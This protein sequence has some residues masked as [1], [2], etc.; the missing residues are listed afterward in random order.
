MSTRILVNNAV[1]SLVS[2]LF[3]RGSLMLATI[4]LARNLDTTRFAIYSYFALT[5]AMLATYASMGLGVTASRFF[6]EV[7]HEREDRERPPL[8]ALWCLSL[9]VSATFAGFVLS[10]PESWLSA[11]L[12]IPRWLL[13]LGTLVMALGVVPGG[14]II[15]LEMYRQAAYVSFLAGLA[16]LV[17]TSLAAMLG[18]EAIAMGTFVIA[19]AINSTGA[20]MLVLRRVGR[21]RLF[22]R[23]CLHRKDIAKVVSFAAPMLAVSFVSGSGAWLLGRM[24]LRGPDGE[25]AFALYSIG[26]QWFAL[27]LLIPGML[28]RVVL[29]RLVRTDMSSEQGVG[30]SRE[31]VR[32]GASLALVSAAC[33]AILGV[34]L[35]PW[36]VDIY[37]AKYD[38]GRW[39]IAAF[40]A[41]AILS[42]PANLVGNAIVA[43]DGQATW[44]LLTLAWL[45]T[46]LAVG[47]FS[48]PMGAWAGAVSQGVAA[49]VLSAL[50]VITARGSRF[51]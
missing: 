3:F 4:V 23:G 28:S 8:G 10:I 26:L 16:L 5:L 40:M 44:L 43:R 20:A 14:A 29:P 17:G 24:I 38:A 13:A 33:V 18:S 22:S 37:G 45:A 48:L 51:I 19:F 27:A 46:L 6:A 15:G 34:A 35:G 32:R 2:H 7:G 30:A 9:L 42:A 11:G 47:G 41:A 49:T 31:M 25:Y 12:A 36:L 39:F 50:A 21:P 1:W